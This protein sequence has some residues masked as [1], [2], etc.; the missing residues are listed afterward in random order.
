MYITEVWEMDRLSKIENE[1]GTQLKFARHISRHQ[2]PS[3]PPMWYEV[4]LKSDMISAALE[5]NTEL[6]L[7]DEVSWT[8][9]ELLECGAIDRLVQKAADVVKG[10][11]G[12]GYWNDNHQQEVLRSA[13][14]VPKPAK[15][16]FLEK[17]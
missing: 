9:Q 15:G 3:M 17:F 7:G 5:E 1:Q 13:A 11:D 14:P 2:Q 16:Q 6:E 12:V 4:C 10:L 8:A